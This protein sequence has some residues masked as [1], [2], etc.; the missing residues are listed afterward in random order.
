V[1]VLLTLT[2]AACSRSWGTEG[3]PI[4]AIPIAACHRLLFHAGEFPAVVR[5]LSIH[6]GKL[7]AHNG[8]AGVDR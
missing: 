5:K 7:P 2:L 3:A 8:R 6:L 1:G 4:R